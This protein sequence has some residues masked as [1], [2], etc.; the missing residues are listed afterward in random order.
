MDAVPTYYTSATESCEKVGNVK[1]KKT[2]T[3]KHSNAYSS[4]IYLITKTTSDIKEIKKN[5]TKTEVTNTEKTKVAL[6]AEEKWMSLLEDKAKLAAKLISSGNKNIEI[7]HSVISHISD[8]KHLIHGLLDAITLHEES[9][10]IINEKETSRAITGPYINLLSLFNALKFY[11][12]ISELPKESIKQYIDA[13]AH[14]ICM[15]IGS[16]FNRITLNFLSTGE[17]NFRHVDK[18][19]G[20]VRISGSAF[21]GKDE[22]INDMKKIKK[23]ISFIK[24]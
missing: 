4:G 10:G 2:A 14:I 9:M 16:N 7:V 11:P 21:F 23:L 24:M 19:T 17:L 13:D 1:L 18:T 8:N 22:N 15:S 6:A 20:R 5:Q 12:V 3:Q